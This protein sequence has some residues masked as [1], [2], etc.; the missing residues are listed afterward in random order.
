M[1]HP[2]PSL[3][4]FPSLFKFSKEVYVEALQASHTG[5]VAQWLAAFIA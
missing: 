5:G 1:F 4:F 3:L 2:F